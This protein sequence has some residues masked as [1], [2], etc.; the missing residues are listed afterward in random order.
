MGWIT[1][2][3]LNGG[4]DEPA[5]ISFTV[6]ASPVNA[7]DGDSDGDGLL[8]S[9]EVCGVP[10]VNLP[11]MGA[12]PFRKD[13]FVEIDWMILTTGTDPHTHEPW[14]PAMIRAW[15]E[16][17]SAPVT[18]PTVNGIANPPGIALHID[19]GTL[20]SP[21]GAGYSIDFD[22]NGTPDLTVPAN[23]NLDLNGDGIPDIGDLGR[24]GGGTRV[25]GDQLPS[26]C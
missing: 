12:N 3:G 15:N 25:G 26:R 8:D 13:I 11:A 24:L 20:Y 21:Q 6:T 4:S 9:W 10:N 22:G 19:V 2:D 14:L 17:N 16:M 1:I 23:G 18:N 5:R 7:V